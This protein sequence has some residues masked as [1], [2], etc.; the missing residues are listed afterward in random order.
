MNNVAWLITSKILSYVSLASIEAVSLNFF[1]GIEADLSNVAIGQLNWE[2]MRD[3]L[4][5][6]IIESEPSVTIFANTGFDDLQVDYILR[7]LPELAESEALYVNGCEELPPMGIY[8]EVAMKMM[9]YELDSEQASVSANG[10]DVGMSN[11]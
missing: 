11:V 10:G 8:D 2:S 9:D 4:N 7:Q 5:R 6:F 3:V 1:A